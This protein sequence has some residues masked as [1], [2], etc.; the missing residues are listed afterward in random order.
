MIVIDGSV[1]DNTRLSGF[2]RYAIMT[3][4]QR[5]IINNF[6]VIMLQRS[7]ISEC[8][9]ANAPSLVLYSLLYRNFCVEAI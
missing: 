8:E 4:M 7:C 6:F 3:I 5:I 9:I 2:D 1:L